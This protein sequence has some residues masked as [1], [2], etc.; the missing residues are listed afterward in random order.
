MKFPFNFNLFKKGKKSVAKESNFDDENDL[1][2]KKAGG[3]SSSSD[4]EDDENGESGGDEKSKSTGLIAKL[5]I[6]EFIARLKKDRR[7]A[8]M[9]GGGLVVLLAA[10][11]GGAW[12][13]FSGGDN[14]YKAATA[15]DDVKSI[16]L[17][18]TGGALTPPAEQ[19]QEEQ[20]QDGPPVNEEAS[21][22]KPASEVDAYKESSASVVMAFVTQES[23]KGA[24]LPPP[25]TSLAEAP[26]PALIDDSKQGPLP[27]I[28]EDGR[29]P[30]KVYARPF[31]ADN[32][33]PRIAIVITGM[34]L[35]AAA[36]E[37]AIKRLPGAVTL[38]FDA[39]VRN[40]AQW[41][42]MARKAGHEIV[43]SLPMESANFPFEDPGPKALLTTLSFEQNLE[44]LDFALSRITGY[45]GVATIMGSAFSLDEKSL[46][47]ILTAIKHRGLML[48][49]GGYEPKSLAPKIAAEISLPHAAS[50]LFL[51]KDLSKAAMEAQ[52]DKLEKIARE[53]A[54]AVAFAE[55]NPSTIIRLAAWIA[56]LKSKNLVLAPISAIADRQN[57]P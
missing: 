48:I 23:F 28:S 30:L 52:L 50:N 49:D 36:T 24:P 41:A 3:A 19:K 14:S 37:A 4:A 55:P 5:K 32:K 57:A 56:S 31:P 38:A 43:M 7:L 17:P 51:D 15:K 21:D 53:N 27:R 8:I 35:S 47:P 12:L 45:V 33:H 26:D 22:G 54:V 10:I 2:D 1:E 44:R 46:K 39:N 18:L 42:N 6:G 13:L 11:I 20:I 34:G 25:E 40:Y 29:S 16:P 9:A